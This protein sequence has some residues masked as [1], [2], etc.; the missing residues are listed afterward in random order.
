MSIYDQPRGGCAMAQMGSVGFFR[1]SRTASIIRRTHAGPADEPSTA[2]A[3][4]NG[5]SFQEPLRKWDFE[6]PKTVDR[7]C[8]ESRSDFLDQAVVRGGRDS[9]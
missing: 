2:P 7:E 8:P 9:R 5:I 6:G 3:P 1:R 4:G